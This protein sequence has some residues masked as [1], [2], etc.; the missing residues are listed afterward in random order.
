MVEG[1]MSGVLQWHWKA[2][3]GPG[4]AKGDIE[5]MASLFTRLNLKTAVSTPRQPLA[6]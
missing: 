2:A 4:E 5:I 6:S 1:G 3:E